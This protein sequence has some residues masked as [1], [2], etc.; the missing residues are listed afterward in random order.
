MQLDRWPNASTWTCARNH[1]LP[2]YPRLILAHPS[3]NVIVASQS[4]RDDSL[5]VPALEADR[6]AKF[7]TIARIDTIDTFHSPAPQGRK[8]LFPS[9]F[10]DPAVTTDSW[11]P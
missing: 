4:A 8:V 3:P 7:A 6:V 10:V 2:G 5:F 11:N 1:M 9:C